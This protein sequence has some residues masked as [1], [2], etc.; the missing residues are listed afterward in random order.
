MMKR[1]DSL[2]RNTVI[3]NEFRA[4]YKYLA[5][6]ENILASGS[7]VSLDESIKVSV[8]LANVGWC[9]SGS[10]ANQS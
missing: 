10:S 3:I 2:L 4:D 9:G 5:S 1:H 8:G 6:A 7:L